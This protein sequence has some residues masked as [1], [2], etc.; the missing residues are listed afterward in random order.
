[1]EKYNSM[2]IPYGRGNHNQDA[3][4]I[5]EIVKKIIFF[6]NLFNLF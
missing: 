2:L 6:R 3:L 5:V 1:M 4:L